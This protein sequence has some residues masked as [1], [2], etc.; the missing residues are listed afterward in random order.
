MI[1]WL[2]S[3][4]KGQNFCLLC[5]MSQESL[6]IVHM[7]K[8]KYLLILFQFLIFGANSGVKGQK[9]TK[10]YRKLCGCTHI[11]GSIH[12]MI[13][14]FG[15]HIKWWHLHLLF[16]YMSV[17]RYLRNRTSYDCGF[18][19]TCKMI[20]PAIFSFFQNSDLSGFQQRDGG[21]GLIGQKLTHNYQF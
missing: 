19:H 1:F 15:T 6:F 14:I 18:W 10:N 11:S 13:V 9:M 8:R 4:I 17:S 16:L 7:W 2:V 20:S 3:G 5:L 21:W 12:H